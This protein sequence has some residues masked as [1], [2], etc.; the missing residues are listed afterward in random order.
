MQRQTQEVDRFW[1]VSAAFVRVSLC[2]PT[3]FD[4]L[5]QSV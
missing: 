4:Q 5:G 2:K 1:T 3:E